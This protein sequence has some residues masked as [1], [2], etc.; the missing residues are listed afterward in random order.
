MTDGIQSNN[1]TDIL[2]MD[3]EEECS[4]LKIENVVSLAPRSDNETESSIVSK[5]Y[6]NFLCL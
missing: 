4:F 1:T 3:T 2:E 5:S 6:H